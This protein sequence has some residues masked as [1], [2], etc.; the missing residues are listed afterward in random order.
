M[1]L[2][3][4]A[5]ISQLPVSEAVGVISRTE[6]KEEGV[7]VNLVFSS[8]I[9]RIY[10]DELEYRYEPI[11]MLDPTTKKWTH[12]NINKRGLLVFPEDFNSNT[13]GEKLKEAAK[14]DD[15]ARWQISHFK[16]VSASG[17]TFYVLLDIKYIPRDALR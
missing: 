1:L 17:S 4:L 3:M 2:L 9:G 11:Y 15:D 7:K 5:L 14:T 6:T 8:T 10:C 16:Y 12:D 13:I